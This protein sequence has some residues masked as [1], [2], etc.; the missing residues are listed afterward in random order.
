MAVVGV[1]DCTKDHKMDFK[2]YDV[3]RVERFSA[4]LL[5][6]GGGYCAIFFYRVYELQIF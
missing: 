5:K 3:T 6:L 4:E 1:L 2:V